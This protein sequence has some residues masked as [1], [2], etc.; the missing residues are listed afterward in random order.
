[1]LVHRWRGA[2]TRVTAS[3]RLPRMGLTDDV[4]FVGYLDRNTTLLDCYYAAARRIRLRLAHRNAGAG[5]AGGDG[6]GHARSS[7]RPSLER[8]TYSRTDAGALVVPERVE[9]FAAAVARVLVR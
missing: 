7:L 2:G 6:S 3:A 1:M 9:E 5:T 4:R 8:S